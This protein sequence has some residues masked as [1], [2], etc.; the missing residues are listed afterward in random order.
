MF[1]IAVYLPHRGRVSPCQE[2]TLQDLHKVLKKVS[3]RDCVV[4]LG[5][6]NE[7]LEAN[8]Q[9]STGEWT[10]G[11]PSKN[12]DKILEFMRM[13]DLR[14]ANTFFEPKKNKNTHTYIYTESKAIASG[15]DLGIYIGERVRCKH[16]D[17]ELDGQVIDVS[18]PQ[19]AIFNDPRSMQWTMK[20]DDG[21]VGIYD[22]TK[23][24]TMLSK[25]KTKK[26]RQTN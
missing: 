14:A 18:L 23:L 17:K 12:S 10:G 1:I 9:E 5:D 15:Q 7:Q 26:I 21:H 2:D 13:Y 25:I 24:K 20:L 8:V 6:F 11:T 16:D 4:I 19:D 22:A 3:S